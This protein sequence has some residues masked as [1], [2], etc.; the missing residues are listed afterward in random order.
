[1]LRYVMERL[2][3]DAPYL[4]DFEEK[5]LYGN[6]RRRQ[7]LILVTQYLFVNNNSKP[8]Q[9]F[10]M[11]SYQTCPNYGTTNSDCLIL[12]AYLACKRE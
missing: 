12:E 7:L 2:E 1:M 5:T 10:Q 9:K 8:G 3:N 11:L 4:K 6:V